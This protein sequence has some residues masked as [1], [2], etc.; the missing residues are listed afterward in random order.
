MPSFDTGEEKVGM[1]D[2][3]DDSTPPT[4]WQASAN[5]VEANDLAES[6][7]FQEAISGPGQAH[8]RQNI[9]TELEST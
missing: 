8:W 1:D 9:Q 2:Q 3:D 5:V 6:E 4:F 7:V